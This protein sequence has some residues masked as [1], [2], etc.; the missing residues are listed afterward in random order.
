M[1]DRPQRESRRGR[2]T[3][4]AAGLLL[5]ASGVLLGWLGA[6]RLAAAQPSEL[7]AGIESSPAVIRDIG[8]TVLATG[9]V[10]P[11]VG[12]QV[13][14]GS[15]VSGV[16]RSLHVTAGD[17]VAAGSLLAELDRVEFETQVARAE[18]SLAVAAAERAWAAESYERTRRLAE[19]SA[20]ADV[21]LSSARR[22]HETAVA[23]EAEAAAAVAAAEVQLAYTTIRAPIAGVIGDISTQQGETVAASFAAPTFLTIVDLDRLEVWAYVD[24][25]DI[26]RIEA[27]QRA[28]FTVDA[29]PDTEFAGR[30]IAIRPTAE[31]IDNVVNYI[32]L[33]EIEQRPDRILRPEMTATVNITIEGRSGILAVPNG[34]LRREGRDT[35]VL[36]ESPTGLLRRSVEPGFRGSE[37]TE[38]ATGLRE[39]ERVMTGAAQPC[40]ATAEAVQ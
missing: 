7:S 20:A 25:T 15:R 33:I 21:E 23:R 4:T 6:L 28:T 34:A 16:L 26:G 10:R 30:V 31:V 3:T 9:I 40:R 18:A 11:E 24:E 13:A 22:Q 1:N 12:A 5:L 36:I 35:Y 2:T 38:I 29:Y 8:A 27:G 39:G 17:R 32:T 14:V 37:Y 19:Q